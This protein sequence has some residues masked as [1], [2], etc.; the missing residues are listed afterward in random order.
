MTVRRFG[1][2]G[3]VFL[4]LVM[5]ALLLP[6]LDTF[7]LTPARATAA[8]YLF[9]PVQWEA[10]NFLGKW[11]HLLWN[12]LPG[13]KPPREE[14]LAIVQEYLETAR[15]AEKEKNRLEGPQFRRGTT[16]GQG[17]IKEKALSD[18][19]LKELLREKGKL[20]PEAEEALEAELSAVLLDEGLGSRFDLIFPP[21]DVRFDEPPTILVTSPRDRIELREAV[22]L[23]PDIPV[24]ERDQL[25]TEV[26][27]EYNVSALVDN[28][29]GL[30]TYPSMVSDLY[31]LR[32]I[33]QTTAHEWLHQY[34]FFRS[35][36]R[37]FRSSNDMFT[38]NETTADLAGRELGDMAFVRMGGD[39]TESAT[40]YLA[41]DE[42][43]PNFTREMRETRQGVEELLAEGKVEEAE[44]YMK[45]RWWFL[46]LRGYRLRKLN[47]AYFAFRGG[48]A[49]SP[50]S[51][52]P[53][54][55]QLKELRS[56]LPDVGTFI[57][58]MAG[59]STYD[60]FLALLTRLRPPEQEAAA[61]GAGGAG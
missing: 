37:N 27:S 50:A 55:D 20:R 26:L 13:S 24:L 41:A 12:A 39:L 38:L 2:R 51:L 48:Y 52:S 40:R 19:Y 53:I 9:S 18:E 28:L 21:V 17:G 23:H 3:K 54:G 42:R 58:T 59:I 22:L 32:F 11:W 34:F 4:A 61:A 7:P 49:E 57:R 43:D 10:A 47:Q 36:G 35:L 56:L 16:L 46:A 15:R 14:R 60:E 6:R 8:A 29:A 33:L 45:D 5:A 44:Q 1:F 25:E 30:A 31:Q